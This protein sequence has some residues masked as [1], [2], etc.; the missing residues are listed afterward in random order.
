MKK[1][2]TV[3]L[4]LLASCST[5]PVLTDK[6]YAQK[7][8]E[9]M[10]GGMYDLAIQEYQRLLEEHPFSDYSEEAQLKIGQAQYQ[11]KQYAEAIASFQDFQR[12][13]PTNPNLALTE[14]YTALAF[15]DQMG[16]RDR[17]QRAAENAQAHFASVLERYPDSP[18]TAEARQ[19]LK[20]CRETLAA[21]EFAIAKFYLIWT[22]PIGAE[23]RLRRLL[24]NYP[25]TD[26]AALALAHFARYLRSR[27]DLTRSALAYASLVSQYPKSAD[28]AEAQDALAD[29]KGKQVAVPDA[30][31]PALVETLGR[32]SLARVPAPAV[33]PAPAPT[34][35]S[36]AHTQPSQ[37]SPSARN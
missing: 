27:G 3:V 12:M 22:N 11:N 18:F 34:N 9:A 30:P 23:G 20:E 26:V 32:P 1:T 33:P 21:H 14:Y 5:E 31:L 15:M 8:N 37:P 25:D 17:D 28:L 4:L 19:K 13:H 16:K 10:E 6:E 24:E 36:D 29:L 7:A 2:L 35:V